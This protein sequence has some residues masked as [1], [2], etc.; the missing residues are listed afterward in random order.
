MTKVVLQKVVE[1]EKLLE[2][3]TNYAATPKISAMNLIRSLTA[4]FSTFLTL[5]RGSE[6][7]K[8]IANFIL[9]VMIALFATVALGL[10]AVRLT[11]EAGWTMIWHDEFNVP[12]RSG[13]NTADWLHDIGTSYQGRASNWGTGE[14]EYM[15]NST[16]NVYQD[17]SGH[18]AIKPIRDTKGNW[19]SGRI[20]TR[21]INFAA[22]AGGKL[23][24]EASIQQPNVSGAAAAGYWPA[25]WLLGAGFRGV[26][27]N[28][29]SIGEI[30]IL[31]DIN[32]RSSVFGTLH[33]GN[34][35]QAGVPN[36]CNETTGIGSGERACPGCQTAFHTYRMEYD[37]GV[38]PE[39][40]C[41]YLDGT[42]YFTVKSTQVDATTWNNAVHHG[43]FIIL[44]VAM[45][46]S[47]PAAF[48][49]G[50]PTSSTASG[51]PML[52]DYVRV[53]TNTG[54]NPNPTPA[55]TQPSGGCTG[56]YN[57]GVISTESSSAQVW[58]T[59]CNGTARYVILHYTLPGQTQQ[60]VNASYDSATGGWK[61]NINGFKAGQTVQYSFTY[62]TGGVQ[63]DTSG[64]SWTHP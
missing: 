34:Y 17:G 14:V 36:P 56:T 19:T 49:A 51:V 57:Q 30:D 20:E 12:A 11:Q 52:V 13:V 63:Y 44:N 38:S 39:Q 21:H 47:F 41:W 23:A 60:N 15:T 1:D 55:P 35:P 48:G 18:L 33:C 64:Y 7:R 54:N 6:T 22:P 43:F 8:V 9:T 45:G 42:N 61:Y 58:F 25:F 53:Y 46:G 3:G 32:G 4:L 5:M 24:V 59:L 28:W 27:D 50:T 2:E 26:Y 16:A 37:R 62:N 29:P 31:E 40:I 10:V